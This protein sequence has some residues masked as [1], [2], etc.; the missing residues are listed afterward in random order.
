MISRQKADDRVVFRALID[1]SVLAAVGEGVTSLAGLLRYLPSVYPTELLAS[2]ARLGDCGAVN[3]AI[4]DKVRDQASTRPIEPPEGRSLL[5][6]PH[7]LDFEWRFTPRASR[8]LLNIANDLT[9]LYADVLLFG[10]PGLAVEAL[11]LPTNRWLS[12]LG[13]DNLVTRRLIALNRAT[14]SALS[15][16]F[17]SA[18]LPRNSCDTVVLDPPWYM[19]FIRPM[20]AAAAAACR[21]D[22]IVLASLPPLGTRPSAESDRDAAA[23][24]FAPSQW[25]RGDLIIFRKSRRPTRP[26]SALRGRRREW[27]ETS[28]GRMRLFIKPEQ[29]P[30]TGLEGLIPTIDGDILPS[31]SRRDPR[32][33]G[34]KVWTSGNRAFRTDN[35]NL[36]LQAALSRSGKH[37]Q[38][39]AQPSL[40]GNVYE[41]DAVQR[42]GDMLMELAVREAGEERGSHPVALERSIPW[43]SSLTSSYSKLRATA[44][45]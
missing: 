8:D 31:V 2:L 1:R 42:I 40:W 19:D 45:G 4:V 12:F 36:V 30:T 27:I 43:T 29:S 28:I 21:A 35:A 44:S 26:I 38:R 32:R 39:G 16:A 33:R 17:C 11:S 3:S 37:I 7:P 13:E 41:R 24:V 23:G 9:P 25:R 34:T 18:G 20:L 5:P 22:G 14:G 10:T 6:L 15:I